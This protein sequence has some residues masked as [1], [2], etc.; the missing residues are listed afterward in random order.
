MVVT[1]EFKALA[2]DC[3]RSRNPQ[4]KEALQRRQIPTGKVPSL[5][6]AYGIVVGVDD[7]LAL[8]RVRPMLQQQID[9]VAQ[10]L[11]EFHVGVFGQP[12]RLMPLYEVELA[13][14]RRGKLAMAFE[15]GKLSLYLPY[16]KLRS[17]YWDVKILKQA[18]QDG[19]HLNRH[20]PR[21][22]RKLWWL[23]NPV[24]LF[25]FN[26]RSALVLAIQK[27]ILG[28]DRLLLK[29]SAPDGE[30]RGTERTIQEA[31]IAFLKRHVR[32]DKLGIDLS[33]ALNQMSDGAIV[34]LLNHYKE[35]LRD[36]Q[37]IEEIID[38]GSFILQDTLTKEQS[39]IDIKMLGFVNVGNYHRIDVELHLSFGYLR[40]YVEV[41]TRQTDV[42][43]LQLGFVNVY[44]IDDITVKPNLHN[45]LKLDF[46]TA[47]LEKTLNEL[48]TLA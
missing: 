4:I 43:A 32:E 41:T 3:L 11:A 20:Y 24:G 14:E 23:F 9:A 19:K 42:K 36:P 44:T 10:F 8:D 48:P 31:A 47:A 2:L 17:R 29:I 18:W 28:L 27:Q 34:Q 26:L 12:T 13:V 45:A 37:Q 6:R 5:E 1:T 16:R 40:K 33:V 38:A 30:E 46:E 15:Q 7:G 39:R 25:R 22:L 35:N 21:R